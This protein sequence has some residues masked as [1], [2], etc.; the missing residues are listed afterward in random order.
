MY[1]SNLD[2]LYQG[3][4]YVRVIDPYKASY[5]VEKPLF[6]ITQLAQTIMRSELGK[7]TMDSSFENR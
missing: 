6:A 7:V 3:V 5:G 4:I 1:E 2:H